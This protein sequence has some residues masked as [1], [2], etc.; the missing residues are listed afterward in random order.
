MLRALLFVAA[1]GAIGA[2]ARYGVSIWLDVAAEVFPWPTLVV[3]LVGSF[4]IGLALPAL[5]HRP[6]AQLLLM[7]GVL[8]GFTT[9]SAFSL[10]VL[11]LLQA[12]RQGTALVYVLASVVGGLALV[13]LGFVLGRALFQVQP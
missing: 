8:G 10:D 9:F 2:A 5:L 4:L 1:G 3:N 13:L 6:L 12:G 11:A 7:T